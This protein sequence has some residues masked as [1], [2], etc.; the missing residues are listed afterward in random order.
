VRRADRAADGGQAA[1]GLKGGRQ[2]LDRVGREPNRLLRHSRIFFGARSSEPECTGTKDPDLSSAGSSD[3]DAGATISHSLDRK[4][5]RGAFPVTTIWE[6]LS[7]LP[8]TQ[9]WFEPGG[10]DVIGLV[11][12]FDADHGEFPA[13]ERARRV[14]EDRHQ[15]SAGFAGLK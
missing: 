5:F 4:A 1:L 2:S 15:D 7:S 10:P 12:D 11:A 6:P 3:S 14:A 8:L 9:G 13:A